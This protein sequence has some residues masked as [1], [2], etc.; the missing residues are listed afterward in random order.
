M[1]SRVPLV[2]LAIVMVLVQRGLDAQNLAF[3]LFERY[4]EPLRVQAGIPGLSVA[5][6]HNGEVAWERGLGHRDVEALH[7]ALPDT[8]YPIA[9]LT[10]TVTA[11]LLGRC[12]EQGMLRIDDRIGRWAPDA[13]N[14]S[15]TL[16]QLVKH[17]V[18]GSV[19]GFKYDPGR[20]AVLARPIE[21]CMD[22][23]FRKIVARQ[24]LDRFAMTDAVPGYDILTVPQEVRQ[25]FDDST[26]TRYS[27]VLA[28]MAVPYKL[29]RR[30]KPV[31][32]ELPPPGLDGARGL[33][34]SARDLAR[35]DAALDAFDLIGPGIIAEAWTTSLHNGVA[36]PFG[37]GWFVQYYQG[38]KLVWQFGHAPDA[39]SSL[40]LKVPGRR[41][42]LILL[43][44]SDGLSA[45]FSLPEGDVTSSLFARTFLRLFL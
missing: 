17:A 35:F 13:E 29:D 27:S 9:D 2:V 22:E 43:A 5:I 25:L 41:L 26:M 36:T 44:N 39:Y 45:P 42:T 15:L 8:P 4:L 16:R 7:P 37:M 3:A 19:T 10:A 14:P 6:I 38:E 31:R 23:P 28:R 40:I 32:S 12:V 30:A 33:V 11:A 18:P 21:D 20:F 1:R 24:V 34:A